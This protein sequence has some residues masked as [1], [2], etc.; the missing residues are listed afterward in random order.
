[1]PVVSFVFSEWTGNVCWNNNYRGS[2]N[3]QFS[4]RLSSFGGRIFR[5]TPLL[6]SYCC[7]TALFTQVGKSR[8]LKRFVA[9]WSR[10]QCWFTS[11]WHVF[12][13]C[14]CCRHHCHRD[15]T[16]LSLFHSRAYQLLSLFLLRNANLRCVYI[17][18]RFAWSENGVRRFFR[19]TG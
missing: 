3:L 18:T 15:R 9:T 6:A 19:P 8:L 10:G 11:V 14:C 4:I 2:S 7:C 16:C 17:S 12:C 5:L 13:C 1:M